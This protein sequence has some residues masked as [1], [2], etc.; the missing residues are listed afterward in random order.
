MRYCRYIV[1][2]TTVNY[3]K[4]RIPLSSCDSFPI[5]VSAVDI[6]CTPLAVARRTISDERTDERRRFCEVSLL[7][8]HSVLAAK[9]RV[10]SRPN[11]PWFFV[12]FFPRSFSPLTRMCLQFFFFFCVRQVRE[13]GEFVSLENGKDEKRIIVY[14]LFG[15]RKKRRFNLT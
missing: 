13:V 8:R 2:K 14:Q 3:R 5:V 11:T 1:W 6:L 9:K 7:P 15:Q 10:D 4:A 12:F